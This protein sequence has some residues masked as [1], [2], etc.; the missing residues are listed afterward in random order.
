MGAGQGAG[1]DADAEAEAMLA[2]LRERARGPG[3]TLLRHPKVA[4]AGLV[5]GRHDPP[6][7]PEAADQ[8]EAACR[9]AL[10]LRLSPGAVTSSPAP[11]ALA[12]ARPLAAALG[13]GVTEDPRLQEL[14]FGAW[15]GRAWAAL[16]RGESDPWA[17]DPW[18]RAPPG[19][20]RFF[21]LCARMAEALAEAGPEAV[22]VS[23]AGPIRA[24]WMLREG[25][26]FDEAFRRAVP[27]AAPVPLRAG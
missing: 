19:G 16:D 26:G 24:A 1:R 18:R 20:E 5:Y 22:M 27:Y 4:G 8:I 2:A 25:I 17:E 14:D 11:R 7:A 3:L 23:H 12:L 13:V 15:E 10:A 9:R 21:D 6:L